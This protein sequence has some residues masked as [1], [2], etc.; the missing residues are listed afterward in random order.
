VH[1]GSS[2]KLKSLQYL[3][4]GSKPR[5]PKRLLIRSVCESTEERRSPFE[6]L[7]HPTPNT[8][9]TAWSAVG[10]MCRDGGPCSTAEPGRTVRV[11]GTISFLVLQVSTP[12]LSVP[13]GL[14]RG[15]IWCRGALLCCL[16]AGTLLCARW[17]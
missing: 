4:L 1:P 17:A 9:R 16:H 3:A 6:S 13:L 8:T 2:P 12:I 5:W 11:V 10:V 15:S 14:L 7:G